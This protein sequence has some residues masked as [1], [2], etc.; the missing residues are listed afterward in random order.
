MPLYEFECNE[1]G[2]FEKFISIKKYE[3]IIECPLC[4]NESHRKY[5]PPNIYNT[6]P[7]YRKARGLNEKNQESP[8]VKTIKQKSHHNH[9]HNHVSHNPWMVGH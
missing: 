4:E 3:H 7:G 9:N 1:C 5:S 2:L 8:K 6:S